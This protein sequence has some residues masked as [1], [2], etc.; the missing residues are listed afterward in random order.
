MKR[1]IGT[2]QPIEML[3]H[4]AYETTSTSAAIHPTVSEKE[5]KKRPP[6]EAVQE[7]TRRLVPKLEIRHLEK[8]LTVDDAKEILAKPI[9]KKT[10]D[11]DKQE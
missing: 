5:E 6:I 2:R 1:T 9:L 10:L 7:Q 11:N 8:M 4:R 3:L